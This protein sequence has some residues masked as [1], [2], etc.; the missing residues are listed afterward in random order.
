MTYRPKMDVAELLPFDRSKVERLPHNCYDKNGTP[1]TLCG[2]ASDGQ[3]YAY[4]KTNRVVWWIREEDIRA[5]PEWGET[6]DYFLTIPGFKVYSTRSLADKY[7]L[8]GRVSLLKIVI[9]KSTGKLL[10]VAKEDV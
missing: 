4:E 3:T 1:I 9:Q 2:A 8:E 6:E 5:E 10:S 7:D